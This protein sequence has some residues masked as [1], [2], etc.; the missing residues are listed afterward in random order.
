M[1]ALIGERTVGT[2]S[3]SL[4]ISSALQ[5]ARTSAR[6][7]GGGALH[8][9]QMTVAGCS[10]GSQQAMW[11]SVC[12]RATWRASE[13]LSGVRSLR[14]LFSKISNSRAA[15]RS[16]ASQIDGWDVASSSSS[17]FVGDGP[18]IVVKSE[19]PRGW[20]R[21]GVGGGGGRGD[22][23]AAGANP[24]ALGREKL[25]VSRSEEGIARC[26]Q[27]GNA[28]G[29]TVKFERIGGA[30][31]ASVVVSDAAPAASASASASATASARSDSLV[32]EVG[33]RSSSSQV[34]VRLS[35][36]HVAPPD[37]AP[38]LDYHR[39]AGGGGGA[40]AEASPK[41]QVSSA[42]PK[43]AP[44]L[45]HQSP[46]GA[47]DNSCSSGGPDTDRT[48]S[49]RTGVGPS[50]AA[51]R[52][53]PAFVDALD[54]DDA[55]EEESDARG[56]MSMEG[57]RSPQAEEEVGAVGGNADEAIDGREDQLTWQRGGGK[58]H[59]LAVVHPSAI[60]EVGAVVR[61]RARIAADC[62]IRSGTVVGEDVAIGI[63]TATGFNVS[64]QN[65][66][67]GDKCMIHN[68]V[69]VGQDGF[70]FFVEE[71]R[72]IKKPQNLRV[73]IGNEV[74]IGANT[75]IDRGSWRDT[76]IGDYT[77]IDNLVQIGHNV[78]MGKCCILCGQVG[79]AGSVTLGDYVVMGGKSGIA[80]H[81]QVT[82]NVRIASKAG[83]VKHIKE[84]GDY[85]GFPAVPAREW[86]R[87]VVSWRQMARTLRQP[88][89]SHGQGQ[90]QN[91]GQVHPRKGHRSVSDKLG[92]L[93]GEA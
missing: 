43:T 67:I 4:A 8:H 15:D 2:M 27:S 51:A 45:P 1:G 28:G 75:C 69:C 61:A 71:G 74:E 17:S 77:K 32:A 53:S 24:P 84:P 41:L 34:E 10:S 38:P 13:A 12:Q 26:C 64:L 54:D 11:Q 62:R 40:G 52:G 83:V 37:A 86:Q 35:H 19:R 76:V 60:V 42:A 72:M 33:D 14:S 55:E 80:D 31:A 90:G 87:S 9:Q 91:T 85:A 92:P 93:E 16:F 88:E 65:C 18:R 25:G 22:A 30:S 50:G 23:G 81:V 29:N 47:V 44:P 57:A 68:G 78:V 3:Y 21:E 7:L 5:R 82:S 66:T 48:A 36:P 39:R 56:R 89:S 79:L 46:G 59:R 6:R 63:G 70:G 20:R 58:V 49:S 73:I